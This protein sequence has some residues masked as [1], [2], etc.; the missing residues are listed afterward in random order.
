MSYVCITCVCVR[1]CFC[2]FMHVV[3]CV[4]ACVLFISHDRGSEHDL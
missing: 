1:A 4:H 2:V 3:V